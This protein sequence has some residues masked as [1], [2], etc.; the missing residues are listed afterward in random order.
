MKERPIPSSVRPLQNVLDIIFF[1]SCHLL[2]GKCVFVAFEALKEKESVVSK[3]GVCTINQ[4]SY[5]R[6]YDTARTFLPFF[7]LL[8]GRAQSDFESICT[9]TAVVVRALCFM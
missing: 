5:R 9:P 2:N 3:T 7:G 6:T 8:A 4:S 1:L